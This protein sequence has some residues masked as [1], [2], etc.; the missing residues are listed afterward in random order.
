[1]SFTDE[2]TFKLGSHVKK[3]WQ[4]PDKRITTPVK[5]HPK[6]IHVWGGVGYCTF[7]KKIW[8]ENFI[9]RLPPEYAPYCPASIRDRWV[10]AQ[11]TTTLKHRAGATRELLDI[12]A[13]DRIQDWPSK[14]PDFNIIEDI[15]SQMDDMVKHTNIKSIRGL[16]RKLTE[17]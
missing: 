1:M 9:K 17:I 4:R 14:S 15:W 8:T 5:R 3:A 11:D 6:K 12:M 13:P 10:L 16:K 2:K 7:L